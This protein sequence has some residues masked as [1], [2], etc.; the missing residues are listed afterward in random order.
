MAAAA[1]DKR[2]GG[3]DTVGDWQQAQ[4][5]TPPAHANSRTS[6]ELRSEDVSLAQHFERVTVPAKISHRIYDAHVV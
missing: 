3:P 4:E 6:L 2:N 1:A 5:T